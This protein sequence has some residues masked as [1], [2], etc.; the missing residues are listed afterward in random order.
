MRRRSVREKAMQTL[1]AYEISKEP[2]EHVIAQTLKGFEDDDAFNRDF[3]QRLIT[4]TVRNNDAIDAT[5]KEKVDNWDF[6][7]IAVLDRV[8]LRMAIC[9]LTHFDDIPPKVSVNEAIELAKA[10]STEK[11]GKFI[12][13]ILDAVL[14]D[15]KKSGN[16][17]KSGRGLYEGDPTSK[18]PLTRK[19]V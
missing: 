12:N 18:K 14:A 16:M 17:T 15:L 3:A 5:I 7:R 19:K 8:I 4:E 11:S 2:L 6:K 13:G 10:Y 9:E 1:Y